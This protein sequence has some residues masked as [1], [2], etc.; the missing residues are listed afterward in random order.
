VDRK[1]LGIT[2]VVGCFLTLV[3]TCISP[4]YQLTGQTQSLAEPERVEHGGYRQENFWHADPAKFTG[5][6][7]AIW[8]GLFGGMLLR[9]TLYKLLKDGHV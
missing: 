5:G 2:L 9:P 3:W 7:V 8:S 1:S 4:R 6:L